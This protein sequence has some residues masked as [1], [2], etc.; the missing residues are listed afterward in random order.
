MQ[1]SK[2]IH[3]RSHIVNKVPDTFQLFCQKL[4]MLASRGKADFN[5]LKTSFQ[6]VFQ[7]KQ[8]TTKKGSGNKKTPASAPVPHEK[9]DQDGPKVTTISEHKKALSGVGPLI[10]EPPSDAPP[11]KL[12]QTVRRICVVLKIPT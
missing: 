9:G 3:F 2:N 5:S 7:K 10:V 11:K 6:R 4:A 8:D 12:K 1:L